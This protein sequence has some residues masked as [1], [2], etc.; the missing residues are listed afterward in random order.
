MKRIALYPG[1]FDPL[2]VGHLDLIERASQLYDELVVAVMTNPNKK[3]YLQADVRVS[4][5]RDAVSHLGNVSVRASH[6]ATVEIARSVGARVMIR[7]LRS[8]TDFE[9]ETTLAAGYHY[10]A[11]EIETLFMVAKPEHGYISSSL[12]R[13][14]HSLGGDVAMLVPA[15][16]LE[17]LNKINSRKENEK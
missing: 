7:G 2:T 11:P 15:P 14:I 1:S 10:M 16:V 8:V 12:I 5:I 17:T 3:P 9:Y 4:G 6:G 13:E